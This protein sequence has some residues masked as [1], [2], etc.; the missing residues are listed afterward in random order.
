MK[1]K[2]SLLDRN[3]D[4]RKEIARYQIFETFPSNS[5][6]CDVSAIMI[7]DVLE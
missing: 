5:C 1:E 2:K 6:L 7:K 3:Y 4:R